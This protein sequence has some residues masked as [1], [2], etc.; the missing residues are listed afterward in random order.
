MQELCKI[1]TPIKQRKISRSDW[2]IK[3]TVITLWYQYHE[4]H[5]LKLFPLLRYSIVLTND[6][7]CLK[8]DRTILNF[9]FIELFNL[10][11]PIIYCFCSYLVFCD[12]PT[13][14]EE[15]YLYERRRS[16]ALNFSKSPA[17]DGFAGGWFT[18]SCVND[19]LNDTTSCERYSH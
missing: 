16:I 18:F 8:S 2:S 7:A 9:R 14:G 5:K 4:S 6:V 19:Q 1:I 17:Y 3:A 15:A 13:T 12:S 10:A 11:S